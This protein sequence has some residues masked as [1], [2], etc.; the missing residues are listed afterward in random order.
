MPK[1]A[2]SQPRSA[3]PIETSDPTVSLMLKLIA[4]FPDRFSQEM[5]DR[6]F[7]E[8]NAWREASRFASP[9]R[10]KATKAAEAAFHATIK[11]IVWRSQKL[12]FDLARKFQGRS[13]ADRFR[14]GTGIPL[15]DLIQE[16]NQALAKAVEQFKPGENARFTTF[17]SRCIRNR[18]TDVLERWKTFPQP[19]E[20]GG[21]ARG[22][23]AKP[24]TEPDK[25]PPV[26]LDAPASPDTDDSVIDRVPDPD[27]DAGLK[28]VYHDDLRER[29]REVL[30]ALTDRERE[31]LV[32]R[33]GL[34]D[35]Y[36]RV[37]EEVGKQFNVTRERIRMI[38]E[39]ALRKLRQ[40]RK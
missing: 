35:G 6:L 13:C 3:V 36:S 10:A 30:E 24:S 26:S 25:L 29:L 23:N 37:L 14:P 28:R 20:T 12:V 22:K 19:R 38:E 27:S 33:F 11:E 7:A 40:P 2:P 16:G 1:T 5:Q 18:L 34:D 39:K 9:S 8:L 31:V 17:A 32:F 15:A 21:S 4:A